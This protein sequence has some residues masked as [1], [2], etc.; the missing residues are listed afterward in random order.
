MTM[1]LLLLDSAEYERYP[2]KKRG[3]ISCTLETVSQ[4]CLILSQAKHQSIL[5]GYQSPDF[6]EDRCGGEYWKAK[7]WERFIN[8]SAEMLCPECPIGD[9]LRSLLTDITTKKQVAGELI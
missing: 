6:E 2:N 8:R 3:D 4:T 7:T 9:S 1:E 5:G